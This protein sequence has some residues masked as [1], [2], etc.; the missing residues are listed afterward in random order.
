MK[1]EIIAITDQSGSMG[2]IKRAVI[3]GF[4]GFV[5]EQ[6]EVPGQARMTHVKFHNETE[7][8][9]YQGVPLAEVPLLD[10]ATYTPCGT[11]A[12][13]DAVC[14][15]LD[16]QGLRIQQ[17]GWADQV[18]VVILTDGDENA[19]VNHTEE[20][21]TTMIAHARKH[22]WHF[23]FLA[24][25]QDAFKKASIYGIPAATTS[26]F[27]ASAAGTTQAYATVG[28]MTRALRTEPA[29][30]VQGEQ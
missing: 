4:N 20:Q 2:T 10:E 3:D 16:A 28:G 8:P 30:Y 21:M 1:T 19:S 12:L 17:E 15:T 27:V 11:T 24:A 18:I 25:N 14:A 7:P 5:Q 9:L 26:N 6:R 13:F 29:T 22:G 23:V